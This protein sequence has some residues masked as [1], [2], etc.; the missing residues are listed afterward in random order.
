MAQWVLINQ[1]LV[2]NYEYYPWTEQGGRLQQMTS[3]SP[4][5]LTSLQKLQY[6]YDIV[7]N[8]LSI[9][10][11]K[12]GIDANTTQMQSFA[13]DDLYRLLS[14][15]SSGDPNHAH[16]VTS[17]SNGFSYQYDAAYQCLPDSSGISIQPSIQN[18]IGIIAH[19]FAHVAI[20][21]WPT[22]KES[23][24]ANENIWL[25]NGNIGSA[26]SRRSVDLTAD[27]IAT[28]VAMMAGDPSSFTYRWLFFKLTDWR[29]DWIQSYIHF[30]ICPVPQ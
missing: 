14:A 25:E 28:V 9:Q 12:M 22:I 1:V 16:A 29:Y 8:V 21:Q 6:S 10:D 20:F 2:N 27:C 15:Q 7:G 4:G 23:Y 11:Y 17:L 26:I 3:G 13:Y 24:K 5:D 18:F 30:P 19:E